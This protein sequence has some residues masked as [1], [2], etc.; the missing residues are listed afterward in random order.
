MGKVELWLT[1]HRI[2]ST[3]ILTISIIQMIWVTWWSTVF[4]ATSALPGAD[5]ALVIAAVQVPVTL[6]FNSVYSTFIKANPL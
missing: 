2:R 1:R 4:A 5:I 6:L 3:V